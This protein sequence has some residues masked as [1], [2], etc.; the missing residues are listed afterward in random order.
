MGR[1]LGFKAIL[2][3]LLVSVV[4]LC[5]GSPAEAQGEHLTYVPIQK[6]KQLF[7]KEY[8]G[9]YMQVTFE[10]DQVKLVD[11]ASYPKLAAALQ[12][13][14]REQQR[15]MDKQD[16]EYKKIAVGFQKDHL[17]NKQSYESRRRLWIRRQDSRAVGIM[18]FVYDYMG[19]VH[20]MYG[21]VGAN[22]D[23]VTGKK[24][25]FTDVV[26]DTEAFFAQAKDNFAGDYAENN[27]LLVAL[28]DYLGKC[29]LKDLKWTLDNDGVTLYFDPYLIGSYADGLL[30]VT[31]RFN[32][33]SEAFNEYYAQSLPNYES[34]DYLKK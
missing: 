17:D 25:R 29:K 28:S 4:L 30:R 8:P 15:Y 6:D 34:E 32:Q 7:T 3:L 23:T 10:A 14:N 26:V 33:L 2:S 18:E 12:D 22:F 16:E 1:L 11:E 27:R 5:S 31:V 9:G 21:V 19:G 24:L 13:Y 20:G